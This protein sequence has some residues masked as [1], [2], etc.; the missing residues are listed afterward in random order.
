[1]LTC[2]ATTFQKRL[3]T[4]K[5]LEHSDS[6]RTERMALS[7]LSAGIRWYEKQHEYGSIEEA[8][9]EERREE[10]S[11]GTDCPQDWWRDF[12]T[13]SP[14]CIGNDGIPFDLSHLT[15]SFGKWRQESIKAAGNAWVPQVAYEIFRAIEE[16]EKQTKHDKEL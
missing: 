11:C 2:R 16:Y 5:D 1:M 12:P 6:A 4:Y 7:H 3:R 14:V 15:I 8:Q 9:Q 10:Q 13:V